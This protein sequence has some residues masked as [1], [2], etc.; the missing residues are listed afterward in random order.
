LAQDLELSGSDA[1]VTKL[2]GL[3][4]NMVHYVRFIDV[5]APCL[6]GYSKWN[7]TQYNFASASI[8][9]D[10]LSTSDETFLVLVILNYAERW[11]EEAKKDAF[12][13]STSTFV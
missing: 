12:K 9:N 4:Q 7:R 11:Y 1:D 8:F 3:R 6:I 2:M 5:F 13:V 10:V